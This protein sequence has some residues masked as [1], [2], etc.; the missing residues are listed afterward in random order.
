MDWENEH[1]HQFVKGLKYYFPIEKD[2][3]FGDNWTHDITLLKILPDD[4]KF[5][6]PECLGG[7]MN[8]PPEDI[9]GLGEYSNMLAV[10]AA[11]K[12]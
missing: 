9:G 4:P 1:L 2:H 7:K 12:Y 3:D 10:L 11:P 5:E 8:C 6:H